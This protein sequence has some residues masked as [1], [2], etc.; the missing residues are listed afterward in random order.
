[1]DETFRHFEC[2]VANAYHWQKWLDSRGRPITIPTD[3][4]NGIESPSGVEHTWGRLHDEGKKTGPVIGPVLDTG[5]RFRYSPMS[6]EHATLF[7]T[8][9]DIDYSNLDEIAGFVSRYGL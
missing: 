9:A 2:S 5:V 3:G 4:L 6:R 1:M 8:F 7:R